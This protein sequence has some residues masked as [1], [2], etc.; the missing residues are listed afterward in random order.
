MHI[1]CKFKE[2]T[3]VQHFIKTSWCLTF[4][5]C[6]FFHQTNAQEGRS[7][8]SSAPCSSVALGPGEEVSHLQRVFLLGETEYT[9]QYKYFSDAQCKLP[10]YSF[11]FKGTSSTTGVS[12]PLLI[13]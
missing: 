2:N 9:I 5:L 3:M 11:V 12:K 13:P 4:L 1:L 6:N 7:E 10:M 8:W